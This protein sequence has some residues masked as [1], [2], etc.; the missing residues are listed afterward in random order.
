M[1]NWILFWKVICIFGFISF[2]ALV[3]VIIPLG[4]RDLKQLFVALSKSA[5]EATAPDPE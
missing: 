1:D 3:I 4:A 2:Y 5:D